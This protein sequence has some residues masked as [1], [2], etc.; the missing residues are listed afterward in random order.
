VGIISG[1]G[2][3]IG[4]GR[5]DAL[6]QT[7]AAINPGNSGGP[8]FNLK[9]E[10]I[11]INTAIIGGAN[12]IGFAVPINMAKEVLPDLKAHGRAIR[13]QLGVQLAPITEEFK[14]AKGYKSDEGVLL[15]RV[16]AGM[17]AERAGL[18]PGDVIVELEGA[19]VKDLRDM[20]NRVARVR[21]GSDVK[22]SYWRDG[23]KATTVA[24]LVEFKE[25]GLVATAP[26]DGREPAPDVTNEKLGMSVTD[27]TPQV[28]ERYRLKSPT[29]ILVKRVARGSLAAEA[30]LEDG[31]VILEAANRKVS[32]AEEF[33]KIV[34]GASGKPVTVLV[35]REGDE[36]F[37]V[38]RQR[39]S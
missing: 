11:G 5:Y 17:P 14:E 15:Q 38:L 13:G 30:G 24:K 7:D 23:K 9:G 34:Q 12:N 29:G 21:P 26:E 8:L 18:K 28:M 37:L 20:Q 1:L 25:E 10:V 2:R 36:I 6:L 3:R 31:D 35:E 22:I 39:K 33:R 16:L 4:I 27:I 19:P 32:S